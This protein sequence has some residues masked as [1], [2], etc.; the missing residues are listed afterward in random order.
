M[1]YSK[2]A[3]WLTAG[4]F[5]T[6]KED[7]ENAKRAGTRLVEHLVVKNGAVDQFIAF[8]QARSPSFEARR[9]TVS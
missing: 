3:H 9:L 5:L 7:V 2:L 8:V 1:S 6:A 4:G